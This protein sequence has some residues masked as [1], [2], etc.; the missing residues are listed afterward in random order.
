MKVL[1]IETSSTLGGVAIMDSVSGLLIESRINVRAVT[2]SERLMAEVDGALMKCG[3]GLSPDID[4]LVVAVGPG[5]F[6]GLRIGLST[7]KGLAFSTGLPTVAVPS[8]E[9]F[10]WGIGGVRALCP[11]FDARKKAVYAGVFRAGADGLERIV[12]ESACTAAELACKLLAL[13]EDIVLA[14]DG[15]I[16]Y[17][18]VFVDLLGRRAVFAPPHQMVSSPAA[19]AHLGLLRALRAEYT[20]ADALGPVYMRRAEAE[21]KPS[22]PPG[23]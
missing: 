23:A 14:G 4:A 5:S 6:T 21:L 8:L 22:G 16:V 2:H 19:L 10:A 20:P 7:V 11:M 12:A 1:A 15:A 3:I 17:R 18:E 13:D 9:A